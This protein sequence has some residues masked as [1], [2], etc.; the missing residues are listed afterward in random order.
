MKRLI[1]LVLFIGVVLGSTGIMAVLPAAAGPG[2]K[3]K[4][5]SA[6]EAAIWPAKMPAS[7]FEVTAPVSWEGITW[8]VDL[9]PLPTDSGLEES[10]IAD[11]NLPPTD[12]GFGSQKPADYQC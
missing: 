9:S 1:C 3:V 5:I 6:R 10:Q 8:R 2:P 12:P 7:G 11:L 4:G